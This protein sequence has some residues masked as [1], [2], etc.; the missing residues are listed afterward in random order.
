M[1]VRKNHVYDGSKAAGK[2]VGPV[3]S[4][5]KIVDHVPID[6]PREKNCVVYL[7][8]G[9]IEFIWNLTIM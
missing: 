7:S 1:L 2:P 8:N 6:G 9:T 3:L 5:V 4:V